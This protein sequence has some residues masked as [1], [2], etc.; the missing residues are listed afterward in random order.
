VLPRAQCLPRIADLRARGSS[1]S[2]CRSSEARLLTP[3]RFGF[4][5]G[6]SSAQYAPPVSRAFSS[7]FTAASLE[8]EQKWSTVVRRPFYPSSRSPSRNFYRSHR[9]ANP[10][11]IYLSSRQPSRSQF[12]SNRFPAAQLK[13]SGA[14]RLWPPLTDEFAPLATFAW[15]PEIDDVRPLDTLPDPPQTDALRPVT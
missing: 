1:S 2:T 13:S 4:A 8:M 5:S 9:Q 11:A 7:R 12:G 15:P 6:L 14:S 3:L 10:G